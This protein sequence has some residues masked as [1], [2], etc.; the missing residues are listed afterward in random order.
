MIVVISGPTATGKSDVA[1]KIC[2]QQGV[3]DNRGIIVSA[4]SVQAYRGVQ[5]G[6]NKPSHIERQQTPHLLIDI[7]D[8]TVPNYNAAEWREDALYCIQ[9]LV[10]GREGV[11]EGVSNT[12]NDTIAVDIATKTTNDEITTPAAVST[13]RKDIED[14]IKQARIKTGY[15]TTAAT[16]TANN[17]NNNNNNNT[18][19]S[20][21][22]P[23]PVFPVVCGGT[24]M[25]LQWLVHGRPDAMRPTPTAI[26]H[27]QQ[28][29]Q[30]YQDNTNNNKDQKDTK[31]GSSD[32]IINDDDDDDDDASSSGSGSDGD[33]DGAVQYIVTRFG[34]E[35]VFAERIQNQIT[36]G[37]W[38]RLRRTLEI[39]LT[40]EE[41][42]QEKP[43]IETG[44]KT[45]ETTTTNDEGLVSSLF[46]GERQ[47]S[48]ESL[49]PYDVRCFFLCPDDRMKHT[50]IVDERCEQMLLK[51]LLEETTE[52]SIA[53]TLPQMAERAIGYRQTLDYFTKNNTNNQNTATNN[54]N[55]NEVI[56]DDDNDDGS[57]TE[58]EEKAAFDTY[59]NDFATAT[60]RY[61]KKQMSWFRKDKEFMFIPISLDKNKTDR[62][63]AATTNINRLC[64]LSRTEYETELYGGSDHDNASNDTDGQFSSFKTKQRN[65][66]QGKK[67][68]FYTPERH[69]LIPGSKVYDDVLNKAI[70][71]RRRFRRHQYTS[72]FIITSNV[73][74]DDT[75]TNNYKK[76]TREGDN[77]KRDS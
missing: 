41:Q 17:N 63:D 65:Q 44:R 64:T 32:T 22:V 6:A 1:A 56:D 70:E 14:S 30:G 7:I 69:L 18:S 77:N 74:N 2:R 71:C 55:D 38:Y 51:G 16:T 3:G 35:S 73:N 34:P 58:E 59:L 20:V 19:M 53:G 23:L 4:D 48:L 54:A 37:D 68:K 67:M 28:I 40:V 36:N 76:R 43:Q 61:A 60:R 11:G 46:S 33:Y 21:P 42:E 15:T 27:A 45:K 72:Q 26:I 5:I 57:R 52:L 25:Y 75:D 47:G 12:H 31:N 24:M 66:E 8:H 9:S 10:T 62:I 49:G 13:R 39:A 50:R 29:I